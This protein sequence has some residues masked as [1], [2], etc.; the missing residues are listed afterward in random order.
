MGRPKVLLELA[1][2]SLV[3]R[4]ARQVL[5]ATDQTAIVVVGDEARRIAR[6]LERCPVE[7]AVNE[8]WRD[9]LATS[10][11]VAIGQ[12]ERRFPRCAGL[13]VTLADQPFVPLTHL[14]ALIERFREPGV[15]V[16]ATEYGGGFGVPA[17]FGRVHFDAL[18]ALEGDFGARRLLADLGPVGVA[19]PEA[20]HDIDT[21]ADYAAAARQLR[22]DGGGHDD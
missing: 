6:D 5:A 16:V 1:G 3:R 8:R 7:L 20:G 11:K 13:L 14:R 2:E 9:G 4:A 12:T 17:V 18:Q 19:C 10:L 22:G 21:P 15:S